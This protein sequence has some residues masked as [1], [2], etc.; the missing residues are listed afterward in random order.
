ME[1]GRKGEEGEWEGE[2]EEGRGRKEGD[3]TFIIINTNIS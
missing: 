3:P 1:R 2:R